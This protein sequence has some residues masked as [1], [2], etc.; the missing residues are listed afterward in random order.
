VLAERGF[1]VVLLSRREDTLRA[2]ARKVEEEF[3]CST[4][5]VAADATQTDS[6]SLSRIVASV[7]D[8]QLTV[9]VNNVGL[10]TRLPE[11]LVDTPEEM[12]ER[13]LNVNMKFPTKL[14]RLLIPL[15]R[16]QRRSLVI[17]VSSIAK[18]IPGPLMAI[19]AG[20]KAYNDAWSRS[21]SV[22]LAADG[23]D[24]QCYSPG[25]VLSAGNPLKEESLR[26]ISARKHARLALDKLGA[27]MTIT[28]YWVH[29][30]MQLLPMWM[31]ERMAGATVLDFMRGERKRILAEERAQGAGAGAGAGASEGV[32]AQAAAERP[33]REARDAEEK[34]QLTAQQN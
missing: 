20:C 1:N 29:R 3:G 32:G 31:P 30:I 24:V 14:T 5:V 4:R 7:S 22:E 12:V 21:L 18:D 8:L 9:L 2:V 13:Q 23:I 11:T 28:A 25:Y 16:R 26:V 19:Y 10:N 33:V 17:N 6:E 27:Q 15:L 34:Q